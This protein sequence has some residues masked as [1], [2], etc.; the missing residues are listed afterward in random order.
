MK[1]PT[2]LTLAISAGYQQFVEERDIGRGIVEKQKALGGGESVG[3]M[4]A[5]DLRLAF[6]SMSGFSPRNVWYMRLLYEAY[7]EPNGAQLREEIGLAFR[8]LP[9]LSREGET[10][11]RRRGPV[12][13]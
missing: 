13:D 10:R 11:M 2:D 8:G 1:K 5:A 4:V 6:P 12:R 9:L 7:S 3:E